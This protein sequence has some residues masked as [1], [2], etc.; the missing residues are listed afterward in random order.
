MAKAD[1]LARRNKQHFGIV[2]TT[3]K[4]LSESNRGSRRRTYVP[5]HVKEEKELH[6]SKY[7]ELYAQMRTKPIPPPVMQEVV[8]LFS[9]QLMT[10]LAS[11]MARTGRPSLAAKWMPSQNKSLDKQTG[12]YDAV[13]L[14][15]FDQPLEYDVAGAPL[16][17][18]LHKARN[19]LRKTYLSYLRAHMHVV[20][21]DMSA[22]KWNKIN[23]SAV[24]SL[25]MSRNAPAFEVHDTQ[26]YTDYVIQAADGKKKLNVA[27]LKPHQIIK[28]CETGQ[29]EDR[30]VKVILANA[31]WDAYVQHIKAAG[32]LPPAL[33]VVDVSGS[34]TGLPMQVA[35]ALG[36]LL[37]EVTPEP[38]H[39]YAITFSANPQFHHIVG[40]TLAE[41]YQSLTNAKWG[42][43]TD[44]LAVFQLILGRAQAYNVPKEDMPKTLFVFSDMQFDEADRIGSNRATLTHFEHIK[45]MYTQAGYDMP[46]L[47]FWNLEGANTVTYGSDDSTSHE[48][49]G[50]DTR[51]PVTLRDDGTALVSGFSA[52]L[53][54]LFLEGAALEDWVMVEPEAVTDQAKAAK[55][56]EKQ[57]KPQ[58]PKMDPMAILRKAI[59]HERFQVLQVLD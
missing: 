19:H 9:A 54:K 33:A 53:L 7:D 13:A 11:V 20:E 38:W 1:K 43:N 25:S 34:M 8:R 59:D 58:K 55:E 3:L 4:D 5:A 50:V 39:D 6:K 40:T 56:G 27:V 21:V 16:A 41:R 44:F 24:P 2:R 35:C 18:S 42:M 23:Y 12:L 49:A 48:E 17:T 52:N 26:R 28:A 22:K 37:A 46:Q 14:N 47:V 57:S 10:D 29:E 45:D 30:R 36:L 51:A 31:Q 15:L 32:T